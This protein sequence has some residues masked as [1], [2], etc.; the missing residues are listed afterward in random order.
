MGTLVRNGLIFTVLFKAH[1]NKILLR[2]M[3]FFKFLRASPCL[4]DTIIIDS[5]PSSP[6]L[7]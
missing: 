2:E 5:L 1:Q 7:N 6:A 4:S 3:F